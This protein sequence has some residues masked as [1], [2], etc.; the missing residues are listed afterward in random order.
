MDSHYLKSRLGDMLKQ[1]E[2]DGVPTF[3][4]F[5]RPEEAAVLAS[6]LKACNHIFY[7][8]YDGASRTYLCVYPDWYE[9]DY[10][11]FPFTAITFKYRTVDK[12]SHK[13]FLGAVMA[14]GIKRET[15][16]DILIEPGRA[17]MFISRDIKK[18]LLTQIDGVG[19]VG[20]SVYEGADFPL[21]QM[22]VKETVSVT[23]A[24][25]R[26]DCVVAALVGV[27]RSGA[28]QLINDGAVL[29]G[30]IAEYKTTKHV[31]ANIVLTIRK[32]GKY[33]ILSLDG[34]TRKGRII[35]KANKY[36]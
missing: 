28:E 35:L 16:G 20:V 3:L 10:N 36:I 17:V 31:A 11:D 12:L 8:G 24:S 2:Y 15:V 33:D 1:V 21:P 14:L 30:G 34:V 4:G 9:C 7:G 18:Y 25:A 19:R 22:S 26:L 32:K 29:L 23:V 13:D 5:L 6:D 27:S